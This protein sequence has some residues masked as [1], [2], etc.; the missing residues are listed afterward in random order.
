MYKAGLAQYKKVSTHAALEHADP[1][2]VILMLMDGA[3]TQMAQAKGAFERNDVEARSVAINK[4]IEI[5]G[6]I[7]DGLNVEQGGE[8]AQNLFALYVYMID[9]LSQA[10]MQQDSAKL[11]EVADLLRGI[12]QSW[13]EIPQE[14]KQV[15]LQQLREAQTASQPAASGA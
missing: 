9:A 6:G 13:A 10:N 2:Q 14:Q 4:A 11:D 7:Q 8:I 1:H 5:I 3:L 15:G 12:R